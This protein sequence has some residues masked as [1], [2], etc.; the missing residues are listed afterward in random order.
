MTAAT[1]QLLAF[2]REAYP[3]IGG[4]ATVRDKI[5]EDVL[6]ARQVKRQGLVDAAGLI[7]CR[8]YHNW[9]QV[10]DGFAKNILA[11]HGDR[12]LWLALAAVFHWL[13]FIVPWLW[14]ALGWIDGGPF[15]WPVWPLTLIGLGIG[16]RAL[17]AAAT[18]QNLGDALLLP[19]STLLMP[20]IAVQ[21]IWWHWRY[22]GPF[23]KGRAINQ[24]ALKHV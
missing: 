15:G 22:G 3:A 11:G 13:I 17:T 8:M 21:A 23:W 1:G 6:L 9:P 14:L 20:R 12:V 24:H 16:V 7:S 10:R 4:H 5:L 18:R 19:V 2:R